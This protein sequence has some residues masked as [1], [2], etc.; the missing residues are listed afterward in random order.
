MSDVAK[1]GRPLIQF[2]LRSLFFA[3]LLVAMFYSGRATMQPVIEAQRARADAAE[4]HAHSLA[5]SRGQLLSELDAANSMLQGELQRQ[6]KLNRRRDAIER[7]ES[8]IQLDNQ[9]ID[10]P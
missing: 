1:S 3:I 7:E 5:K 8:E 9:D 2:S 4:R 10:L 6:L